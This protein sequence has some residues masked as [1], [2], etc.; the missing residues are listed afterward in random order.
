MVCPTTARELVRVLG[1]PKFRLDESEIHVAL[2][3]FLPYADTLDHDPA[4]DLPRRLDPDDQSFLDLA[5]ASGAVEAPPFLSLRA[6]LPQPPLDVGQQRIFPRL[7][8][9]VRVGTIELRVPFTLQPFPHAPLIVVDGGQETVGR[10]IV[11]KQFQGL[12]PALETA[13]EFRVGLH[14]FPGAVSVEVVSDDL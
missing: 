8:A 6:L 10:R 1:Y 7:A 9:N 12:A 14:E 5:L 4:S 2:A 13:F 3:A 11:E